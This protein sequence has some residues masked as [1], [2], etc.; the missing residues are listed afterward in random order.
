MTSIISGIKKVLGFRK[1]FEVVESIMSSSSSIPER[2][3]NLKEDM[4]LQENE[5]VD[6]NKGTRR[7]C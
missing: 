2:R 7:N 5:E 1:R 4:E 3:N 6:V